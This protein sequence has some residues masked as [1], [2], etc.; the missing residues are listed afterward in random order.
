MAHQGSKKV[1]YA[2]LFGNMAITVMKFFAAAVSGSSAMIAEGFHSAADTGNQ[3]MLLIGMARARRPPDEGHPFGHGKEIYFWAFMVAV[4]IFLVGAAFSLYEGIHK[5]GHPEPIQSIRMP[6]IVLALSAAFEAYPWW[7]A[8]K[9]ARRAKR[10]KGLRGYFDMAVRSKRPTVLVVLFED[11]A[12]L[13]GILV[14]ACGITLSYLAGLP[15]LDAGASIIIGIILLVLALFLARETKAL[16]LGESASR[17]DRQAMQRIILN[18]SQV[19]R[20][21]SIAT[22]HMGPRDILVAMDIE[23]QDGLTTDEIEAAID[24]IETGIKE[25]VPEVTRIYIEAESLSNISRKTGEGGEP[26]RHD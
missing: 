19:T 23:F 8:V 24:G 13:L 4:S 14:A 11:T 6:L 18:T 20:L 3:L 1:V 15:I 17:E 22:M 25:A 12:A 7:V 16:L 2:A 10:M 9:E 5:I 26:S 21:G